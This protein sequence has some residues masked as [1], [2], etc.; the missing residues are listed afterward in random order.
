[1]EMAGLLDPGEL[2]LSNGSRPRQGVSMVSKHRMNNGRNRLF[3]E[4][5]VLRD[6]LVKAETGLSR[7]AGGSVEPKAK[8]ITAP[9][10]CRD[11]LD[12]YMYVCE[13]SDNFA[14]SDRQMD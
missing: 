3:D 11:S 5:Y 10:A 1:M 9:L 14:L 12:G 2:D 13:L 8:P 4:C 7:S 6:S